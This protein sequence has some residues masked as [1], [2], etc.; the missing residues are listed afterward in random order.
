MAY[1]RNKRRMNPKLK[2]VLT[3]LVV[4]CLGTGIGLM[5]TPI[6]HVQEVICEG[7]SRIQAEEITATA[8]EINGK[9][10]FLVRLSD[11]RRNVEEISMVEEASVRRV[12]P[13]K[14]KIT[15]RECIPAGYIYTEN[16]CVLLDLEGK[17]LDI[18]ADERVSKM[19]EGFTPKETPVQTGTKDDKKNAD[20]GEE[21]KGSESDDAKKEEATDEE[22]Q[23]EVADVRTYTVPLVVGLELHKPEIGKKA[24]SKEKEK[25]N[26]A[27]ALF[28]QMETNG[29]LV[30]ATYLDLQDVNDV[31][32]VI[33]NRLEIQLGDL[34]NIEYRIAFL[35]KVISE[36][37]SATEHAIMDYRTDDIYVRQ[38]EDGKARM[39]ATPTPAPSASGTAKPS[40]SA[41]ADGDAEEE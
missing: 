7:N 13:N 2:M 32:L 39:K 11:I 27:F 19:V 33:E 4:L 12:F 21:S 31:T 41:E 26:Q 20:N 15:V 29:L 14:I 34:E 5:F 28:R 30:R 35:A 17:V 36:R 25:Y 10:I 8:Q 9:N 6:F 16:Q 24:D 18:I 1:H 22:T 38:P 23:E 37:I 3:F 40:A